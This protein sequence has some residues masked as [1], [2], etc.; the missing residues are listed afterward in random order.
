MS[1]W[2]R[3]RAARP[4]RVGLPSPSARPVVPERWDEPWGRGAGVMARTV[5]MAGQRLVSIA[6]APGQEVVRTTSRAGP[7]DHRG[8]RRVG[9]A[10]PDREGPS[11]PAMKASRRAG[12]S[13]SRRVPGAR[14][15]ASTARPCC[16]EIVPRSC[17][18]RPRPRTRG[19]G[20][21]GARCSLVRWGEDR[22]TVVGRAPPSRWT[23]A[24][25][26]RSGDRNL[27]GPPQ[28]SLGVASRPHQGGGPGA[29]P[30]AVRRGGRRLSRAIRRRRR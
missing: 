3:D 5:R 21:Q 9:T 24:G 12:S 29:V 18:R 8:G 27:R 15:S 25:S 13:S 30:A 10:A 6:G 22:G 19:S 2:M 11:V 23:G 7:T 28:R 4:V 1:P 17:C 14:S 26:D 20:P 16:R